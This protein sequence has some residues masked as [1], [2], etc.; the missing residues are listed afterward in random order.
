MM[1][2]VQCVSPSSSLAYLRWARFLWHVH[3]VLVALCLRPPALS[4]ASPEEEK[5]DRMQLA[6][7]KVLR[8]LSKLSRWTLVVGNCGRYRIASTDI[9]SLRTRV[10]FADS[11]HVTAVLVLPQVILKITNI[12]VPSVKDQW[13]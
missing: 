12:S 8:A 9:K 2:L 7:T 10:T 1:L 13:D 4:V 6:R 5:V 11:M 3:G